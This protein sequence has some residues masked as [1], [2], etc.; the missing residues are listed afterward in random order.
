MLDI[1]PVWDFGFVQLSTD[2]GMTWTSLENEFTTSDDPNGT[3]PD[4]V[5]NF[6]GLT[7]R[8]GGWFLMSF[9]LAGYTG[10]AII[11]F[12]YMTDWGTQLDGW[13]VD[14]VYISGTPVSEENFYSFYDPPET[15]F[16]VTILRQ[17]FWDGEYYYN[18]I[19]EFDV[20]GSNEFSLD[21]TDFLVPLGCE[22]RKP[23]IVLAITPRV[24][25]ADYSFS[26]V[27]I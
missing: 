16:L 6:P 3:Y 11:R 23:D 9:D 13:W 22:I 2:E 12:R 10:E 20:S 4:I 8:S 7:G 14:N 5:A 21:L 26:V 17:D 18:L 1:E 25:I 27:P 19:A 15:S 24:G